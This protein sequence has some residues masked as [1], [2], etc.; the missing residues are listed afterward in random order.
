[1]GRNYDHGGGW[2]EILI[3]GCGW[4]EIM[5]MANGWEHRQVHGWEGRNY[6]SRYGS[7]WE[8]ILTMVVGGKKF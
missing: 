6:V 7:E 3:L 5:R 4:E 1:M 8:E 2:E